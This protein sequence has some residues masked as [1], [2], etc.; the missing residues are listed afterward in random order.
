MCFYDQI[1]HSCNCHKWSHFR[2][3][4]SKEHRIGE[5]CSLKLVMDTLSVGTKCSICRK[6]DTKYRLI[7]NEEK[8]IKRWQH[9]HDRR[10]SIEKAQ[11]DIENYSKDIAQLKI[12]RANKQCTL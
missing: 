8:R 10:A 9:E 11:K 7:Q 3:H 2:E 1:K 6:I 12:E 4:C 5:A